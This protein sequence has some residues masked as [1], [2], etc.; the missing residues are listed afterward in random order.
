MVAT[1][2]AADLVDVLSNT[3]PFIVFAPTNAAFDKQPAGAVD[4]M[5]KPEK[6]EALTRDK[7]KNW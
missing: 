4:G 5:S 3:G 2:K 1:V 7:N 6:K